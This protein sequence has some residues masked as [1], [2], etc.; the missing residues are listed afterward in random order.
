MKQQTFNDGIAKIYFVDDISQDG[1]MPKR[2]INFKSRFL[3][4]SERTVGMGRFWAAKQ[5]LTIINQIVRVQRN[6]SVIEHDVVVLKD[7][8]QYDIEQI[9]YVLDVMPPSM[10]LSLSRIEVAYAIN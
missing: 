3:R 2:R 1:D 8:K 10:D 4:Y 6:D 9:Q 7:G 5:D